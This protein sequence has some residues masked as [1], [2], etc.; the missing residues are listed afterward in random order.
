MGIPTITVTG[1]TADYNS[2]S[3]TFTP[4][5]KGGTGTCKLQ[6]AGAGAAQ[7]ACGTRPVTLRVRG[8][9]PNGTYGYIASVS[10][11]AGTATATGRRATAQLRATVICNDQAYCGTGIWVYSVP[12]QA[13]PNNSLGTLRAG[14]Q[15][16]PQCHVATSPAVNASP[17]GGRKSY[18]WLRLTFK[19][20]T[21]YFPFGWVNTDGGNNVSL[22]RTC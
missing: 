1:S 6:I 22:L 2:V 17:W 19:G 16:T 12:S 3:V 5:A 4:N 14:N 10:T 20:V 11:A 8:L 21:G 7:A 9:W 13:N 15:F 18:E